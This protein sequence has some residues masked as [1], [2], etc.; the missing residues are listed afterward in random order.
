MVLSIV[1]QLAGFFRL[2]VPA[3]ARRCVRFCVFFL[4]V[5]RLGS[6]CVVCDVHLGLDMILSY[7]VIFRVPSGSLIVCGGMYF[8]GQETGGR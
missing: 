6:L 1:F 5:F 4:W 3:G 2:G 7:S 8:N